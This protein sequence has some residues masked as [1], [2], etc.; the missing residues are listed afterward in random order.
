MDSW[1]IAVACAGIGLI[2]GAWLNQV[3]ERAPVREPD[4]RVGLLDAPVMVAPGTLRERIVCLVTALA[5]A[6]MG[7]RFGAHWPLVTY[8]IGAASMVAVSVVDL[9]TMRIPDRL[10][11]PSLGLVSAAIVAVSFIVGEPD[12][13]MRAAVGAALFGGIIG[14]FWFVYPAGM[15]FGDVKYAVVLGALAGWIN[16]LLVVY[17]L[18]AASLIGSVVGVAVVVRSGDRKKAFPFGPSLCLGTAVVIWWSKQILP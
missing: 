11:F 15:G 7:V 14:L 9:D 17:A 5:F 10:T 6:S 8:L 13:M 18:F 1:P 2:L 4:R 3:I 16:P 12:A